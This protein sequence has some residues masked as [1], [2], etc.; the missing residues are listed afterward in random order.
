MK[1]KKCEENFLR[2]YLENLYTFDILS[3]AFL[4]VEFEAINVL[5][6]GSKNFFYAQGEYQFFKTF[7]KDV[8]LDGVE[9]DAYRLYSN[10]FTRYEVAKFY[11]KGNENI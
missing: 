4:P 5:D 10:F 7:A 2:N 3:Q 11:I 1:N 9:L 8:F 6:I